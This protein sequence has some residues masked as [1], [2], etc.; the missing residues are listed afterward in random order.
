MPV[1]Q[2]TEYGLQGSD[3]LIE[4]L[5]EAILK[6]QTFVPPVENIPEEIAEI[7]KPTRRVIE[8]GSLDFKK[9]R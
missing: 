5:R 7:V 6:S 3:I 4:T 2:I 8:K 1:V 9:K